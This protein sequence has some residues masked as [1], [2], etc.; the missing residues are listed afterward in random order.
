MEGR[1]SGGRMFRTTTHD[2]QVAALLAALPSEQR[3]AVI[4]YL[5]PTVRDRMAAYAQLFIL[6]RGKFRLSPDKREAFKQ[7]LSKHRRQVQKFLDMPFDVG[8]G[9]R[10]RTKGGQFLPFLLS[11][12]IPIIASV[13]TASPKKGERD[14][15]AEDPLPKP[16]EQEQT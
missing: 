12:V 14:P 6:G 16:D 8:S 10:E 11:A 2:R 15:P 13:I 5:D 4:S 3:K 7:S 9:K 1:S